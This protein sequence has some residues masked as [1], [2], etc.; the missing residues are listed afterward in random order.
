MHP[1]ERTLRSRAA[2]RI[3]S[4][5]DDGD[6]INAASPYCGANK[7]L[8]PRQGAIAPLGPHREREGVCK[9][10]S[11]SWQ[12]WAG[13]AHPARHRSR[14]LSD[15]RCARQCGGSDWEAYF[16]RACH[17][18]RD[19]TPRCASE[20]NRSRPYSGLMRA[21]TITLCQRSLS[22]A[23]NAT[24]SDGAFRTGVALSFRSLA[25]ASSSLRPS[26]MAENNFKVM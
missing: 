18:W 15:L 12:A 8:R 9:L 2:A 17:Q 26:A 11:A 24:A 7:G 22:A 6:L 23:M 25:M 1:Q 4:R 5:L 14:P 13:T 16:K 3:S 21:A 19:R 10:P 20:Q